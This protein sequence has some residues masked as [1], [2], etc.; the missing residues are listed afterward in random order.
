MT[1][2][3]GWWL[4]TEEVEWGCLLYSFKC[5][6]EIGHSF[7]GEGKEEAGRERWAVVTMGLGVV[8]AHRYATVASA[9]ESVSE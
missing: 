1:H 5:T 8:L 7:L 9:F 4:L 2:S 3:E 6:S